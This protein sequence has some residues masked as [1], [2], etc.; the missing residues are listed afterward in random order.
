MFVQLVLEVIGKGAFGV[1][2]K[3]IRKTKG[4]FVGK[5]L[6]F[7][8]TQLDFS[9]KEAAKERQLFLVTSICLNFS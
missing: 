9:H 3:G 8:T 5:I 1:V 2:Y 7:C 6:I 4:D